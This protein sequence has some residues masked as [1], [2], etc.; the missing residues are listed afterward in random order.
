MWGRT[1]VPG[2]LNL[3]STRVNIFKL[4]ILVFFLYMTKLL[5]Y[6]SVSVKSWG[7]VFG[8]LMIYSTLRLVILKFSW[9]WITQTAAAWMR[10]NAFYCDLVTEVTYI[11]S[12][13]LFGYSCFP[14]FK[15]RL[16][17]RLTAYS[18]WKCTQTCLFLLKLP[19]LT[20]SVAELFDS[21]QTI[22]SHAWCSTAVYPF[23]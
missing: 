15:S 4:V 23:I 17:Q 19:G 3:Q 22:R 21:E 6:H 7:W 2:K 18:M 16:K 12:K 11:T 9:T 14:P 8:C 10:R 5:V 1:L 20:I 13:Y